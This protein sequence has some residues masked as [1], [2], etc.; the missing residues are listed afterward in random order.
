[1]G[2]WVYACQNRDR[3]ER[4]VS[5]RPEEKESEGRDWGRVSSEVAPL[6]ILDESLARK[7]G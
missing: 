6:F 4:R 3:A 7:D 2:M 5:E 1:M